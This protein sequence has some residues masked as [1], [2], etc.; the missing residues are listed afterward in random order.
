[1]GTALGWAKLSF[2]LGRSEIV[3]AAAL[4]A[5]LAAAALWLAADMRAALTQ[6]GTPSGP[7][8]CDVIYAFQT[9]HGHVVQT[10]QMAIGFTQY[11]V[12][13]VLGV[14]ILT[15]EIEQRTAMIT[16]PLAGSR[17]KWLAWRVTP[18]LLICLGLI[19]ALAFAAEQLMQ[20]YLPHSDLGFA[21]HGARGISM[22]TRAALVLVAAMAVGA[23][24]GRVL[25]A[26][27]IGIVLAAGLS[28]ALGALLP[29]WVVPAELSQAESIFSGAQPLNTGFEY[30]A[31]DGTPLSDEVAEAMMQ[32]AYE[33]GGE[34]PDPSLLPQ[35]IFFGVAASRYPEVLV[36]ES[37]AIA[38]ATVLVGALAAAIVQRR[39]PE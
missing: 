3:F 18:V 22:L 6:C 23:L 19:G 4:C 8:A 7:E 24:I 20:A 13:L 30:R 37:A 34:E 38:G 12:P 11:A 9:S 27:L 1:M 10:I 32:A 35:E 15:R 14:A 26:L 28:S 31:Q 16:W 17:V 29:V 21:N 2:K 25:P 39:R 36:R 5:G 33:E